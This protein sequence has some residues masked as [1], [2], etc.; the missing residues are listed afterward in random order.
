M[1]RGMSLTCLLFQML[2]MSTSLAEDS[3]KNVELLKSQPNGCG[4]GWTVYLVPDSIPLI[5]CTFKAACDAHDNCYGKCTGRSTDSSAPECEYLRCKADGDLYKSKQCKT[6][7]KFTKLW[8]EA[9][10]RRSV[11]DAAIGKDIL[12]N[13]LG[14]SVCQAFSYAYEK[15]VRT[16]GEVHFQGLDDVTVKIEQSKEDY[17]GAIRE[18]FVKGSEEEFEAFNASPPSFEEDLKYVPGKGLVNVTDDH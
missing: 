12:T 11:C 7:V 16:F 17:E 9:E 2:F 4:A 6:S 13:N 18:F 10:K 5:K 1:L 8:V 14:R 15:A 3:K